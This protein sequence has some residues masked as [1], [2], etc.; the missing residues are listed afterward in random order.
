MNKR[1]STL[2]AAALVAGGL[3]ANAQVLSDTDLKTGDFVFLKT[4]LTAK[5]LYINQAGKLDSMDL[6]RKQ[7]K[8]RLVQRLMLFLNGDIARLMVFLQTKVTLPM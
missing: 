1:F 8:M 6:K 5:A 7:V 3:S 4:G 2:V